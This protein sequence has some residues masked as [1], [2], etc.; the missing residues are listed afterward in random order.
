M[1]GCHLIVR[2]MSLRRLRWYIYLVCCIVQRRVPKL[3]F[4]VV[5]AISVRDIENRH[6]RMELHAGWILL[7]GDISSG[8]LEKPF[9][10][11]GIKKR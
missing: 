6:Q 1:L 8:L 5:Q 11:G 10:R 4:H 9:F 7:R 2:Q 3:I